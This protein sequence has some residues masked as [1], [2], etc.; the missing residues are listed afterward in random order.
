MLHN[1][2]LARSSGCRKWFIFNHYKFIVWIP[3]LSTPLFYLSSLY[4]SACHHNNLD[5]LFVYHPPEIHQ[6]MRKR[7]LRSNITFSFIGILKTHWISFINFH[8]VFYEFSVPIHIIH[9]SHD[10]LRSRGFK[11]LPWVLSLS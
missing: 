3:L 11:I 8:I 10:M 9:H 5:L 7:S 4:F 6:G 1:I 2:L